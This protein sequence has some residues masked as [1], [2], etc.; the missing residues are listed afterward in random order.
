MPKVQITSILGNCAPFISLG[1]CAIDAPHVQWAIGAFTLQSVGMGTE[2]FPTEA[3]L[4]PCV[5][6]LLVADFGI[7]SI[8]NKFGRK[9]FPLPK[10]KEK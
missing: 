9:Q 10:R 5:Q 7:N 3:L 6:L 2:G 1:R 4:Y 8:E